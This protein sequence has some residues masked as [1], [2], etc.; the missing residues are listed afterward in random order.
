MIN[1]AI[2]AISLLQ[3]SGD[4]RLEPPPTWLRFAPNVPASDF[5]EVDAVRL[6]E[7][8]SLLNGANVIALS[9]TETQKLVESSLTCSNGTTAFLV[10]ALVGF[11]GTGV[12]SMRQSED[13]LYVAH[14]SLGRRTPERQE[15][16]LVSC[17][18]Q[19][20]TAVYSTISVAE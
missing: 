18:K 17:L 13:G 4:G 19:S 2:F 8:F 3:G 7:A 10:R 20:P 6:P 14:S 15:T 1:V 5:K 16:A 12:F 11:R 9:V